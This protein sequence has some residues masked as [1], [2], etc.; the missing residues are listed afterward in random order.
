MRIGTD[1]RRLNLRLW[2]LGVLV[3]VAVAAV[4]NSLI[5]N[6]SIMARDIPFVTKQTLIANGVRWEGNLPTV[7]W[8]QINAEGVVTSGTPTPYQEQAYITRNDAP[9]RGTLCSIF[10]S[11]DS[12]QLNTV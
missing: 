3:D 6:G 4:T 8:S 2:V 10:W 9:S 5:D 12:A 7:T 1:E 11:A